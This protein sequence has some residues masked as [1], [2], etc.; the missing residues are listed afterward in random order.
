MRTKV[1]KGIEVPDFDHTRNDMMDAIGCGLD[2]EIAFMQKLHDNAKRTH[3]KD[4]KKSEQ[5]EH[6][7]NAYSKHELVV[8]LAMMWR[9]GF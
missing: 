1:V 9:T 6:V 3:G 4:M 7:Y 5:M 8:M 2:D